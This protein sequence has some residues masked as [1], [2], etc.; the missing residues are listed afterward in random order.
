MNILQG[1][2]NYQNEKISEL[3]EALSDV[4]IQLDSSE[5]ILQQTLRTQRTL[6][7]EN[8]KYKK[9]RND[10]L[11]VENWL[12]KNAK[13]YSNPETFEKALIKRFGKNNQFVKDMLSFKPSPKSKSSP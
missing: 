2:L 9:P 4:K 8:P 12:Q 5:N 6:E 11:K 10:Y 1:Q 3:E 13:R 7:K